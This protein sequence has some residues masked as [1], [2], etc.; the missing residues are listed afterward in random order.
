MSSRVK[1]LF[2]A[3]FAILIGVLA[4]WFGVASFLGQ[5]TEASLLDASAFTADPPAPL[6]LV[7]TTT[8]I[9][10]FIVI[11]IVSLWAHGIARA[12]A[13]S[14]YG[15]LA[16]VASQLLKE[17][18]LER[19]QLFELEAVNTFPSGH[20]TVFS[21]IAAGAIWALPKGAR[22]IVAVLAGGLMAIVAWQL[23]E[24]GWHRPSDLIGAQALVLLAFALAAWIGPRRSKRDSNPLG[25]FMSAF[26]KLVSITMT[27]S[28]VVLIIGG[29]VLV[30]AASSVNSD[31]LM[32]NAG[33]IVLIGV[34]VLTARTLA[35][36]CP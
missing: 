9:I 7:S 25:R 32:L 33:E 12:V 4:Y 14:L 27:I 23:L 18:W 20:M 15:G 5:R 11:V 6:S 30:F 16:L 1:A 2:Y 19:P 31:E 21:V 3:L 35:R 10:A 22:S 29:L 28:G 34:S 13:F 26:A 36:L 17:N 24:Y 8:V